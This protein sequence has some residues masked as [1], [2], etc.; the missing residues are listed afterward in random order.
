MKRTF[1]LRPCKLMIRDKVLTKEIPV[2]G[3][4]AALSEQR[5]YKEKNPSY[6]PVV[7]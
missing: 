2:G 7:F 4:V 1:S 6:N 5:R 3:I